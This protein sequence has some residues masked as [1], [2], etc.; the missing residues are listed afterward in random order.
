MIDCQKA[1]YLALLT[2][3][4]LLSFEKS[5]GKIKLK[6]VQGSGLAMTYLVIQ[7]PTREKLCCRNALLR[8]DNFLRRRALHHAFLARR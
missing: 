7:S 1:Q 6:Q 2:S 4:A 5:V 8:F 3:L